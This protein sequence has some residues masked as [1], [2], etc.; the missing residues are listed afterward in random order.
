MLC[1]IELSGQDAGHAMMRTLIEMVKNGF[2]K[3]AFTPH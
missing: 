1:K 3:S 2:K